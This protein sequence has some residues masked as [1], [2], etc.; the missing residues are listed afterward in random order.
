MKNMLISLKSSRGTVA[1]DPRKLSAITQNDNEIEIYLD[2]GWQ[3]KINCESSAKALAAMQ[4]YQDALDEFNEDA[5][6]ETLSA[7]M[8]NMMRKWVG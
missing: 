5:G 2:S 1:F 8:K 3:I 4:A 7:R 6:K